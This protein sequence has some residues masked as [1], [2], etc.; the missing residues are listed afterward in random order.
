MS[1]RTLLIS[2]TI[3]VLLSACGV[4]AASAPMQAPVPEMYA[5]VSESLPMG[6]P[7]YDA[8]K[9]ASGGSGVVNTSPETTQDRLVIMNAD[10][11]VVVK[12]PQAKMDAISQMVKSMEG[13]VVSMNMYETYTANGTIAP[14]GSISIR[15]PA[16][17]L[18]A[19][20][21]QIKSDAVEVKSENR[22]GQDVT[23][24]YT[25]LK[26]Q[27]KNLE[28]AEQDL[29]AIMDEAKNNPNSNTTSKTQDVLA[30][31]NQIV[32]VRGQIEQIKGQMQYFEQ[33]SSYSLINVTLIAEETVEP[34][35]IGGWQ[36]K[37]VAL[38][39]IQNLVYFLESLANFLIRFFL[40]YL[41]VI[42]FIFGPIALVVW[43]IVAAVRR[44]KAKKAAKAVQAIKQ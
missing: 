10:V 15:V 7:A 22:S 6:A 24:Q 42:V 39:A 13:F 20:M 18:D 1:K 30:V 40:Y 14:Q 44:N 31:Y 16:D 5:G 26:S 4:R 43:G 25:D 17:K 29:L 34:V 28:Q 33:S 36:P 41:W 3:A 37:G 27:L 21:V 2:V 35:E 9:T 23:S 11:T 38:K 8:S 12:D 32:S 19:A